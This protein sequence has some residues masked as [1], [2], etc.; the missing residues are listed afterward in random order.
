MKKKLLALLLCAALCLCCTACGRVAFAHRVMGESSRFTPAQ[1]DAAMDAVTQHFF[2][3]FEGCTLT[4][5]VYDEEYSDKFAAEWAQQYN[6][7]DAVVL[8]SSFDV[9][10]TSDGSLTPNQT[11]TRWQWILTCDMPGMWTLQTWGYG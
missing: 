7:R 4:E 8:L 10:P 3:Y 6:A 2:R 9:G 11:Y 5:L 1:L